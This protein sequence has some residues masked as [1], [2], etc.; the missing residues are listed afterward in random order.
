MIA[1]G[2]VGGSGTRVV[3]KCLRAVGFFLGAD[4]N[5]AIDNLWFT[6]LFKRAEITRVPEDAFRPLVEIFADAMRSRPIASP[7]HAELVRSLASRDREQH[8]AAWL[9]ERAESLLG[10]ADGPAPARVGW[11]EPN[12][13]VVLD[14]LLAPLPGLR[15]VHVIR[16]GLDMAYSSNQYQP[17]LWG[18]LITGRPYRPDPAYSLHYWRRAHERIFEIGRRMG[19]RFLLVNFEDFCADPAR[20][21]R[22]LADFAGVSLDDDATGSLAAMVH[23]PATAGRFRR[24]GT[25]ALDPDDVRYVAACGFPTE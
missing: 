8:P 5:P 22:R 4:L 15:Y 24:Q 3:A 21:V 12:T 6:L 19:D 18:P 25:D 17:R 7:A 10:V 14:R 23:P 11:K 9:R 13:H 1:I 20:G 2:G 16:N